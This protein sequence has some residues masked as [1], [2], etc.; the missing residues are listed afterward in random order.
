M[1]R[2]EEIMHGSLLSFNNRTKKE[3]EMT[4]RYYSI[5]ADLTAEVRHSE[6]KSLVRGE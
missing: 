5:S 2:V 1:E 6:P 3:P 4:D